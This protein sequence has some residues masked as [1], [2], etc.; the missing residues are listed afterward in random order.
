MT[1]EGTLVWGSS[2]WPIA[3]RASSIMQKA[4][5]VRESIAA[6]IFLAQGVGSNLG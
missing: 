3:W 1:L 4:A 2:L 6:T 5:M